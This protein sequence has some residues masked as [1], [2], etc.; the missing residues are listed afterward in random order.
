MKVLI[1]D[2]ERDYARLVGA[3]LLEEFGFDVH[4]CGGVDEAR[5]KLTA[6]GFD[7][8]VVDM[9]YRAAADAYLER[10]RQGR[11]SI[12]TD[13]GFLVSGLAVMSDVNGFGRRPNDASRPPGTVIWSNMEDNR[14]LQ[15]V[16]AYQELGARVFSFKGWSDHRPGG[17]IRALADA[18]THAE[19]GLAYADAKARAYLPGRA[20]P[21]LADALFAK[22]SWRSLWRAL[23]TGASGRDDL[24][25]ATMMA[26]STVNN[27]L[28]DMN[29]ALSAFDPGLPDREPLKQLIAYASNNW[30]FF[31]DDTVMRAYPPDEARGLRHG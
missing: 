2:D 25:S 12:A 30:E 5:L 19:Q 16:F 10:R 14:V 13:T 28:V 20:S 3:Q 11:V 17:S 1:V 4:Y 26:K 15:I 6:D 7:V 23:A 27:N 18:I 29:R 24:K 22:P 21:R 31:L 9:R 8:V